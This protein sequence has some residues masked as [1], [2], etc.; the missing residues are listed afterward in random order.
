[1]RVTHR[2]PLPRVSRPVVAA[3]VTIAL[4]AVGVIALRPARGGPAGP[5]GSEVSLSPD[6]RL[7]L[8]GTWAFTGHLPRG[9]SPLPGTTIAFVPGSVRVRTGRGKFTYQVVS[10]P[11]VL[12]PARYRLGALARIQHGGLAVSVL[13][14]RSNQFLSTI[15]VVPH[16]G[17]LPEVRGIFSLRSRAKVEVILSNFSTLDSPSVWLVRS[18][19]LEPVAATPPPPHAGTGPR[20]GSQ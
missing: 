15:R 4:T 20:S 11:I 12:P 7:P 9:W 16:G 14:L 1:M 8:S 3:L 18:I 17:R 6:Q 5:N 10:P 2:I 13:D 19:R